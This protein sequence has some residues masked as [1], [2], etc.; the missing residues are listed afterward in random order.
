MKRSYISPL[1]RGARYHEIADVIKG[2][3][4]D[5]IGI[6]ARQEKIDRAVQAI[7]RW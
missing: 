4:S 2:H 7:W 3:L 5:R 6:N 1:H